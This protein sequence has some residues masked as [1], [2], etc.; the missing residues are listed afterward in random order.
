MGSIAPAMNQPFL[1]VAMA[2]VLLALRVAPITKMPVLG[3]P[4][5][6]HNLLVCCCVVRDE[7]EE[8]DTQGVQLCI[9]RG[10]LSI[11]TTC[12]HHIW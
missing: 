5:Q 8:L 10:L 7:V 6:L 3:V 11:Y 4:V 1:T 2:T 12:F 9:Q